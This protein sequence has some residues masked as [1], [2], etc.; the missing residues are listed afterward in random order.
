MMSIEADVAARRHIDNSKRVIEEAYETGIGIISS[1]S[2]QRDRLKS[3][4]RKVLDVLNGMGLSDSTL[5]VIE[6]RMSM[7]KL[8][9]YGGMLIITLVVGFLYWW[10]KA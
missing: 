9:A 8:I 10:L 5:R 2:S 7:D 1:M 4:H 6:R 3:A